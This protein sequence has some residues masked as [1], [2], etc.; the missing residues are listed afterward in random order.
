MKKK[1][2]ITL[3]IIF[4]FFLLSVFVP[5]KKELVWVNDD[6]IADIGHSE[7]CYC[8]IYGGNITIFFKMLLKS[9]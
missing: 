3:S 7:E 6:E 9:E 1:V 2:L 8:N 4:I 5:V